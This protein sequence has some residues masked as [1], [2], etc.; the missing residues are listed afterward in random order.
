MMFEHVFSFAWLLMFLDVSTQTCIDPNVLPWLIEETLEVPS[1]PT[2][3][4]SKDF[5]SEY[6]SLIEVGFWPANY[7][8]EGELLLHLGHA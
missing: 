1:D 5:P 4:M 2:C 6:A 8:G 3:L 7:T